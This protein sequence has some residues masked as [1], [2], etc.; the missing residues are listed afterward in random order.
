[1]QLN[2]AMAISVRFN[3][4][5]GFGAS[6]VAYSNSTLHTKGN[7]LFIK[8]TGAS[9]VRKPDFNG[10][11]RVDLLVWGCFWEQELSSCVGAE[12]WYQLLSSG[13][14][15]VNEGPIPGANYVI[16]ARFGNLNDDDLTDILYPNTSGAWTV[17]FG[18]GS[19]GFELASGPA[20]GPTRPIR[21][22]SATTT[23]TAWMTCTSRRTVRGSG[24]CFAAMGKA[25]TALRSRR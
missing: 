16:Q 12:R 8:M 6:T 7:S 13:S 18:R 14:A 19:G 15:F 10:D 21:R 22:S 11:S 1:M 4:A 20:M 3:G 5:S 17:G 2:A 23:G 25:W 9:A 24:T